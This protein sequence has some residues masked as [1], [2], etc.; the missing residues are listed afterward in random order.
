MNGDERARYFDDIRLF[1]PYFGPFLLWVGISNANRFHPNAMY[2]TYPLKTILVAI[3]LICLRKDF[4]ELKWKCSIH[5]VWVGLLALA[6]WLIPY[7]EFIPGLPA[8]DLTK[9]GFNPLQFEENSLAMWSLIVFRVGGASLV[10]P[11]FEEL[12]FRSCVARLVIN[13]DFKQVP[14]GTFSWASLG[15]TT[16]AFMAG[17]QDWEWVGAVLVGLMYYG[18]VVWRKNILDCVI[19]HGVTNFGLGIYVLVRHEWFWW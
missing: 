19:A 6:V 12:L 8:P 1:M 3:V 10:V 14:V 2:V 9:P 18:L 5:G 15:I 4:S 16:L 13:Q 17:H 11:V 7:W